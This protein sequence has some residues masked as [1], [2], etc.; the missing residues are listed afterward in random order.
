MIKGS[1]QT[2]WVSASFPYFGAL[3]L[4]ALTAVAPAHGAARAGTDVNS[5]QIQGD[6]SGHNA[7]ASGPKFIT[8]SPNKK[9]FQFPDG[10]PFVP[11]GLNES[12]DQSLLFSPQ[13]L[14]QYFRHLNRSG[15]NTVRILLDGW[16]E[17]LVELRVGQFNPDVEKA[18]DNLLQAAEKHGIY[19]IISVWISIHEYCLTPGFAQ[20]WRQHPYN[21][22]QDGGVVASGLDLLSDPAA[23]AAQKDR[24]AYFIERW[25]ASPN[26]FAWEF[27][28]EIDAMR[29]DQHATATDTLH[30]HNMWIDRIG[31]FV[32]QE[33]M[34]RFGQHHLRTVSV[35]NAGWGSVLSG[36]YTGNELDFT[37]YHTYDFTGMVCVNPWTGQKGQSPLHP[38]RYFEFTYESA[39]LAVA[40]SGFRPVL[41]TEDAPIS[42][43][44]SRPPPFQGFTQK[45]LDDLF[46]GTIWTGVLGGGAGGNLR[47]TAPVYQEGT[48]AENG[49]RGL[50]N[51][52]YAA[53][54][55]M[56]TILTDPSV[57]WGRFY[58]DEA[59]D[60]VEP[61]GS[62]VDLDVKALSDQ[63][64][65]LLLLTDK[66][67]AFERNPVR[68][69]LR[70]KN[71]KDGRYR[72]TWYDLRTGEIL[73]RDSAYGPNFTLRT[74]EF[75]TFVAAVVSGR[76]AVGAENRPPKAKTLVSG[77]AFPGGSVLLNGSLST[78]LDGD[79]LTY[80]WEQ[81]EGPRTVEL[82]AVPA[83][84][85]GSM[86]EFSP[87][88]E[89]QYVFAL[90]VFD[91]RYWSNV[92]YAYVQV[93]SD[94]PASCVAMTTSRGGALRGMNRSDLVF[95]MMLI[96][97][98]L[99]T[100]S[101]WKRKLLR[102]TCAGRGRVDGSG[103]RGGT[104]PS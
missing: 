44:E 64:N 91:G 28:N 12:F 71:L 96:L 75:R 10:R 79:A 50:S 92:D 104:G 15:V 60:S 18:V 87:Y 61:V 7:W 31:A 67:D 45:Q 82:C 38:I 58:A 3:L 17:S 56:A 80:A 97:P 35:S 49:Y 63:N 100:R 90:K 53:Q 54:K 66:D 30:L 46:I 25:G 78:D 14:D 6:N 24:M 65:M 69:N 19:L 33:E 103:V 95:G 99:L 84:K 42:P 51:G 47:W 32:R 93:S 4:L 37:S 13:R 22:N 88:E 2:S 73:Q 1:R 11:V 89:G 59:N 40:K 55:A 102:A 26:I 27:W 5:D 41:G 36:V 83:E 8:V 52:M 77:W 16:G 101:L 76:F 74:P 57:N 86:V 9:F 34:K 29:K 39:R 94:L 72:L 20:A 43:L 98:A 85:N 48:G 62:E 23:L 81:V 21:A 70:F 68:S